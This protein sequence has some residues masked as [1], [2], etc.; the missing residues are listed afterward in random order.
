MFRFW[1]RFNRCRIV[2]D[3]SRMCGRFIVAVSCIL[4]NEGKVFIAKRKP[5][6]DVPYA[7]WEFPSGRL[8]ENE[9]PENGLK[10]EMKEELG[11][12]INPIRIVDAY[13]IL[14][15][16][17]PAIILSYLC[18]ASN[19]DIKLVEH[20][21]GKWVKPDKLETYFQFD[22]QK[23]TAKKILDYI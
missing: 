22:N 23:K 17:V 15:N 19:F 16:G 4:L 11:I 20:S 5:R 3:L 10:R 9:D 1:K 12:D 18:T 7:I 13:K 8:E 2:S 6:E 21:E 14:R